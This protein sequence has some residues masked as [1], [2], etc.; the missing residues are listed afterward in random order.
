VVMTSSTNR[1]LFPARRRPRRGEGPAHVLPPPRDRLPGLG[2]GVADPAQPRGVAG[3]AQS[4]RQAVGDGR[5]LVGAPL[6]APQP[7]KG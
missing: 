1:M 2:R 4:A 5:A 3:Q 6:P 7:A